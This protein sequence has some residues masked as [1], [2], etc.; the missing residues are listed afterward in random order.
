MNNIWVTADW[1]F[2]H[3][4][5]FLYEPRG[6]TN[7]QDHDKTIIQL[8]NQLVQPED[9]VYIL[10]DL[11]LGEL[12]HGLA[13]IQKMNGKLHVAIGNHCTDRRIQEYKNLSNIV[14]IQFGYR[15]NYKHLSF[16][17]SHY[18]MMMKNFDDPKPTW[19]LSGHTHA[20][21]PFVNGQYNICCVCLDAWNNQP[22]LLDDIVY[23]IRKYTK[24]N[25]NNL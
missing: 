2:G 14:D 7:I 8:H 16:W 1:H 4:K 12:E 6:F 20:N 21:T 15:F 3:N 23:A 24:E 11:T 10:G 13:C 18:P 22:V 9:D 25:Y 19:N 17:L 5:S